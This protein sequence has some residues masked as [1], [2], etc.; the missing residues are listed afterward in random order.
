[1][2]ATSPSAG[3]AEQAED[4]LRARMGLLL[5]T[6]P[7]VVYSFAASGDYAPTVIRED[8][9]RDARLLL[10][11]YQKH[12]AQGAAMAIEPQGANELLTRLKKFTESDRDA[13]VRGP[14]PS[15]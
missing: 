12:R 15:C 5:E 13:R 11:D 1:M 3:F 10:D 9:R 6:A 4:A 2:Q 14:Q 7:S 8:V